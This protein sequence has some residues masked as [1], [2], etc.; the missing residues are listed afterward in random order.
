MNQISLKCLYLHKA[1]GTTHNFIKLQL[2]LSY[3][4]LQFLDVLISSVCRR[5]ILTFVKHNL[6]R[7]ITLTVSTEIKYIQAAD[8]KSIVLCVSFLFPSK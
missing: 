3:L 2:V 4:M 8:L 6:I 5:K 7:V 1:Q